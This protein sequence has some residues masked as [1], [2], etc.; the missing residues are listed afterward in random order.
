M[1]RVLAAI[2][3]EFDTQLNTGT[4]QRYSVALREGKKEGHYLF[5]SCVSHESQWPIASSQSEVE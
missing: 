5:W 1:P 4:V 2:G 3:T